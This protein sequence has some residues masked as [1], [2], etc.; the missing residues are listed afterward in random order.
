[1]PYESRNVFALRR[2]LHAV[3]QALP[4]LGL[5]LMSASAARGLQVSLESMG[6]SASSTMPRRFIV[7]SVVDAGGVVAQFECLTGP[8]EVP[9]TSLVLSRADTPEVL[10]EL[11]EWI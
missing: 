7:V 3:L 1:V 4:W 9:P 10:A 2:L 8:N 6:G 5:M 11:C